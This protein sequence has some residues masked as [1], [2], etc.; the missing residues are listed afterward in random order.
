MGVP[1]IE[2]GTAIQ[3]LE[4]INYIGCRNEQAASYGAGAVGYLTGIPGAC[5]V[6]SGPGVVHALAGKFT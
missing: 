3:S 6:V 5:L 4:G 1:V 2:V